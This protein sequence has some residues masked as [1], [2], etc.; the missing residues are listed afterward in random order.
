MVNTAQP[1]LIV[2]A[3]ALVDQDGR[4]LAQKRP[5][6]GTMPDLWEFPG[7]KIE[8]GET[9]ELA[10][11]RELREELGIETDH[12]CLSPLGFSSE[13]QS[14]THILLL[15]YVCRKWRGTPRALHAAGLQ[16]LWPREFHGLDMPLADR[17]LVAM[18]DA[19]L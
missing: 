8:N 15:L 2:V 3:V 10:L 6:N 1:F 13:V 4:V 19:L 12:A 9:P 14:N 16:W 17:P 11:Q 7:G 5:A 18:M